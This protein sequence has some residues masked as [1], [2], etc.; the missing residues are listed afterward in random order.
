MNGIKITVTPSMMPS[1]KWL[2]T[3]SHTVR[4]APGMVLEG[5]MNGNIDAPAVPMTPTSDRA[6]QINASSVRRKRS[7]TIA[8]S[9]PI[10]PMTGSAHSIG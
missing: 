7:C 3:L 4:L 1:V 6:E 10:T 2:D 8:S 9:A 5:M